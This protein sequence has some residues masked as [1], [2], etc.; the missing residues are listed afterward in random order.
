MG[1]GI[2][3]VLWNYRGYGRSTGVPTPDK[4]KKD[5]EMLVHH[6]R[7][8]KKVGKLGVHG[9]SLGGAVAAH[10]ARNCNLDFLFAD[11]SFWSL[12]NVSKFMFGW[13]VWALFRLFTKWDCDASWD[14]IFSNCYKVI[15]SDPHD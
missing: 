11:R 7:R 3:V 14:F 10:I 8:N 13:V 1:L 5:G 15:S 4:L 12:G 9:E 2:N 6:L